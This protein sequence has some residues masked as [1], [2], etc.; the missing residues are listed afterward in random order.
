MSEIL[1][2]K[3]IYCDNRWEDLKSSSGQR[4]FKK[5][6]VREDSDFWLYVVSETTLGLLVPLAESVKLILC[7]TG[8]K[9]SLWAL[10]C[11]FSQCHFIH[12]GQDLTFNDFLT[13]HVLAESLLLDKRWR[14]NQQKQYNTSEIILALWFLTTLPQPTILYSI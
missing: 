6:E 13:R 3:Q 2:I 10:S 4:Q 5:K 7:L 11:T 14:N 8:T 12:T 1:D 9:L